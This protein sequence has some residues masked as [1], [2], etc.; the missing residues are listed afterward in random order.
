MLSVSCLCGER[1]LATCQ[2]AQ[3][4]AEDLACQRIVKWRDCKQ[5]VNTD[6]T[7]AQLCRFVA[8]TKIKYSLLQ[9]KY[10][11]EVA[12]KTSNHIFQKKRN[13]EI[14]M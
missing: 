14:K 13:E 6:R 10:R 11:F 3:G 7:C 4:S 9:N 5:N 2:W 8:K 1:Y 12:M